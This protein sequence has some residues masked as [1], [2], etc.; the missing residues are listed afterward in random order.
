MSLDTCESGPKQLRPSGGAIEHCFSRHCQ[1]LA[2]IGL[3]I[4]FVFYPNDSN[5]NHRLGVPDELIPQV[6]VRVPPV[7]Y[8][9]VIEVKASPE[10]VLQTLANLLE[11]AIN[12]FSG[13]SCQKMGKRRSLADLFLMW[14]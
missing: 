10:F 6:E 13:L 14:C 3:V 1:L 5:V 8:V 12:V 7:A 2:D 4:P 9:R 11:L